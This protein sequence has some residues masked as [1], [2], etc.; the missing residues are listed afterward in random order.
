L[1]EAKMW[2]IQK[3]ES[4]LADRQ[5]LTRGDDAPHL[6]KWLVQHLAG[7]GEIELPPREEGRPSPFADWTDE[8]LKG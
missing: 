6:G 2:T 3:A 8:D 5:K 7:I 1:K 4:K